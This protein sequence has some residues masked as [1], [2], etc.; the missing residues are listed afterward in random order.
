VAKGQPNVPQLVG[1]LLWGHLRIVLETNLNRESSQ[2]YAAV[3]E[4][5]RLGMAGNAEA[6]A[7]TAAG[8]AGSVNGSWP[9]E[10]NRPRM[11]SYAAS[12]VMSKGPPSRAP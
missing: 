9:V 6:L 3:A 8:A 10:L 1:H 11:A 5:E 2:R 12:S 4:L 7:Y